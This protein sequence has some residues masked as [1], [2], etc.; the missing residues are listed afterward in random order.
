[1]NGPLKINVASS[2]FLALLRHFQTQKKFNK[3]LLDGYSLLGVA[4]REGTNQ[5]R[6]V[7]EGTVQQGDIR[8]GNVGLESSGGNIR[9]GFLLG[10]KY[11]SRSCPGGAV[12]GELPGGNCPWG[13]L[14]ETSK[15]CSY[16][17]KFWT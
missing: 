14:P 9:E 10:G 4:I 6:S 7:R 11:P 5:Q 2:F 13:N 3:V 15:Y 12:R 8:E 16:K 17:Q 1:M